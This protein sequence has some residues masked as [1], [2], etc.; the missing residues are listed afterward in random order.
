MRSVNTQKRPHLTAD[1]AFGILAVLMAFAIRLWDLNATSLWYDETFVLVHA[2]EGII[3]AVAGLFREDNALPLHGLLLAIWIKLVGDY[4]F[5]ARYLS[6]LLGT[7]G[8]PLVIRVGQAVGAGLKPTADSAAGRPISGLGAGLAYAAL[9]IL[10]Y[11]SQEVRLYALAM[12]LAAGFTWAGWRLLAERDSR[13]RGAEIAYVTLGLLMMTAHLFAGLAWAVT[14][15]WGTLTLVLTGDPASPA[16]PT[17]W[18]PRLSHTS[19]WR[20]NILLAALAVPIGLWALWRLQTDATAVSAIPSEALRWIPILFGVGQYLA[21]PWTTLFVIV[22]L[23]AILACLIHTLRS[24]QADSTLWLLISLTLP[25]AILFL[26]TSVKAKWSERYLLSSWG[27]ALVVAI[28]IGWEHLLT[29][30]LPRRLRSARQSLKQYVPGIVGLLLIASWFALVAPALARQAEGTWAVALQDEWHPRPDFRGVTRY[31]EKHATGED[32]IVVV[33]GY[34]AVAIDYY[35]EGTAHLF[36][37]PLG[38]RI[39]DT[40]NTVDLQVLETLQQEAGTRERIWLVLWQD[41]LADPTGLVQSVLVEA[42]HRLPVDARFTNVGLLL[43]DIG[44][45]RPLDQLATPA[46][47]LDIAFEAPIRLKG[48]NLIQKD[49]MWEVD[50]WW[51]T[52]GGIDEDYIVFVHLVGPDG[53]MIAQHDHIAGD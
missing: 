8:A 7:I 37:I 12:P 16:P 22:S 45:C 51:H 50:L 35:Y 33:G 4:E 20:A 27:I 52:T 17:S 29:C 46:F 19:W 28:G 43:F 34:A 49:N 24:G 25:I 6:V 32:A 1:L 44:S 11:Y 42:C 36:G 23:G 2:R 31:I 5:T 40:Q 3:Q 26:M 48:Y 38:T 9:P 15:I 47:P 10:V 14:G 30:S 18:K 53:T 13:K 39:L 41:R 21:Q